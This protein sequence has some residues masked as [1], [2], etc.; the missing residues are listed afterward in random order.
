M[1][2]WRCFSFPFLL[3]PIYPVL[4]KCY[5]LVSRCCG[6][7]S[8]VL[9]FA[10]QGTGSWGS[11]MMSQSWYRKWD[12]L[13][14]K[15]RLQLEK[16][17]GARKPVTCCSG[18]GWGFYGRFNS[19]LGGFFSLAVDFAG[20][21]RWTGLVCIFIGGGETILRAFCSSALWQIYQTL[22]LF[23]R[24]QKCSLQ[25]LLRMQ[26]W[27]CCPWGMGYSLICLRSQTQQKEL[28]K[29]PPRV[30]SFC[31]TPWNA[32]IM[33]LKFLWFVWKLGSWG[34]PLVFFFLLK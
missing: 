18:E 21:L 20:F 30:F 31:E 28:A 19:G 14:R 11:W 15:E 9:T 25:H 26:E 5:V 12:L 17:T 23:F 32:F 10:G 2:S 29:L 24:M 16:C 8:R 33:D 4:L 22:C 7:V 6:L 3:L 27:F 34:I 1:W 13:G